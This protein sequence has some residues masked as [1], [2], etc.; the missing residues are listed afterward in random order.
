MIHKKK[1]ELRYSDSD[2]MGV[3]YHANYFSFFEQ[4]RTEMLKAF[5]IDYY[6]IENRG[7]IFPVRDVNCTYLKSV[8]LG[9]EIYVV[10][11]IVKIT[12]VRIDFSHEL[13]TSNN[14]LKAKGNTSIIS[15]R[16]NDFSIAKMDIY[17][18]EVYALKDKIK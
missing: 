5:G 6:E 2:Q 15:V 1:L 16:K 11:S 4:G 17:L 3:V 8:R 9:E 18:P 14:E 7:F 13:V 12:K 10:T